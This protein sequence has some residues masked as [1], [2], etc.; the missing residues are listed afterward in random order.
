[1]KNTKKFKN[2][3]ESLKGNEQDTLIE[4]IQ[5]GFNVCFE[6]E[7]IPINN[8]MIPPDI[9]EKIAALQANL[10]NAEKKIQIDEKSNKEEVAIYR[11]Q[12][13]SLRSHF[14]GLLDGK[15]TLWIQ[16]AF[17]A[18]TYK[19]PVINVIEQQL[20]KTLELIKEEL[21]I[22]KPSE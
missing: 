11:H 20:E 14:R 17:D 19:P 1:M 13:Y 21:K 5:K 7:L 3:L 12:L 2:F 8:G 9:K 15:L 10:S 6:N 4:S 18:V 22:L 16:N